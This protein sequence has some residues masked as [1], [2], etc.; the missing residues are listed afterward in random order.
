MNQAQK[1]VLS[2][3]PLA[4]I[5]SKTEH[6][7]EVVT[8]SS[9]MHLEKKE[10]ARVGDLVRYTDG[11]TARITSGAGF[12]LAQ[13]GQSIAIVGSHVSGGDRIIST[14]VA[15]AHLTVCKEDPP[16]EGWL[17]EGYKPPVLAA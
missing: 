4:V 5:G 14:P 3:H 6:G 7:G 10:V 15:I 8:A 12:A 11:R 16:I 17:E 9:Q 2:I 13:D 1:T